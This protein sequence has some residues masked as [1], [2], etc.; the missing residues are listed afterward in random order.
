MFN[1]KEKRENVMDSLQFHNQPPFV[2]ASDAFQ[3]SG[4]IRD[5]WVALGAEQGFLGSPDADESVTFDGVGHYC[6]FKGGSIYWTPSTGAFEVH[7]PIRAKWAELGWELSYLGYPLTDE[8]PAPDGIGRYNKFQGGVIYWSPTGGAVDLQN[9]RTWDSGPIAF[10]DGTAL[11]GNCRLVMNNNGDWTFSGHMHDSGFDTYSFGVAAVALTPSG[12]G[13][14][15][16]VEGRAEGTSAGL[17]FGTPNRE[18]DWTTSGNNPSVRDNWMQAAQAAFSVR[19]VAQ[20]K[21]AAGITDTV[22]DALKELAK[23]GITTAATALVA[24]L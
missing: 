17:P 21:L 14:T 10:S 4:A 7:G 3:V 6:H 18:Y 11:G 5:K 13:Y 20:D 19:V 8:T 22:Q 15:L 9:T 24:L 16:S 1:Q 2:L 23:K 12:V